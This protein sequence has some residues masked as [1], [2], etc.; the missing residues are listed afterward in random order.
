MV[1]GKLSKTNVKRGIIF[2]LSITVFIVYSASLKNNFTNWDDNSYVVTNELIKDLSLNNIPNFFKEQVVGNFHPLTIISLSIDYQLTELDPYSYHLHNLLL[3]ILNTILVFYFIYFLSRENL[4]IAFFTALTFGIHP[5]HVESVAWV[6]ERKDVLYTFYFLMG[7][8]S[9]LKFYQSKWWKKYLIPFIFFALSGLSKSAAVVFPMVLLLIDLFQNK[10]LVKSDLTSKIP[11]FI[12]SLILGIVAINTQSE[13]GAVSSFVRHTFVERVL[14][15]GYGFVVYIIKF[16]MPIRLNNLYLMPNIIPD[17]YK[18]SVFITLILLAYATYKVYNNKINHFVFGILF[19][20]ITIVLVLQVLTVGYAVIS[21]RYTYVPYIGLGYITFFYLDKYFNKLKKKEWKYFIL[22]IIVLVMSI[23]GVLAYKRTKVW[24]NS[25]TLW[26]DA[27]KKDK[28]NHTAYN[29]LG[30]YYTSNSQFEKAIIEFSKSVRIKPNY[31]LGFQ[32]RGAVYFELKKYEEALNDFNMV[33]KLDRNNKVVV[34]SRRKCLLELGMTEQAL[35]ELN[36]VANDANVTSDNFF[37]RG[38]LYY[39]EKKYHVAIE[40][41]KKAIAIDDKYD[42]ASNLNIGLSLDRLNK[43]KEAILFF[44]KAIEKKRNDPTVYFH[45]GVTYV[46]TNQLDSAL[47][48]F[49][50]SIE[51]GNNKVSVYKQRGYIYYYKKDYKNALQDYSKII[52]LDSFNAEAFYNRSVAFYFLKDYHS[53]LSDAT[54][55]KE[56]GYLVKESYLN[57]LRNRTKNN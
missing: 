15:G 56:L 39:N 25:E 4:F 8:I 34:D 11:F 18:L 12:L 24:E 53:A 47:V 41:F 38:L 31:I 21:E 50:K 1:A 9:Y 43:P 30:N 20:F 3:H 26:F 19:Y 7:L 51:L 13:A 23:H 6:S 52:D 55:A 33:L 48:D 57:G 35:S 46:K 36:K 54:K 2:F 42:F 16:F 49:S 29:N 44:S 37:D 22:S 5:M 28:N 14:Y 17:F 10:K 40:D 27:L 45:R 32:N